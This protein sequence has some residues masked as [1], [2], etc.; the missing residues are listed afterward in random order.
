MAKSLFNFKSHAEAWKQA[1]ADAPVSRETLLKV[2]QMH[3]YPMVT[4]DD[5]RFFVLMNYIKAIAKITDKSKDATFLDR[6]QDNILQSAEK[7]LK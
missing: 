5:F 4:K 6:I 3:N 2:Q 1:D 7:F